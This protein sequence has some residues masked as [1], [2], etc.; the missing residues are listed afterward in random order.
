MRGLFDRFMTAFNRRVERAI[1]RI[2]RMDLGVEN[3]SARI[4]GRFITLSGVAPDR[5]VSARVI[6]L[7]KQ[8]VG[9]DNILNAINVIEPAPDNGS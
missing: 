2:E 8:Y 1:R 5:E 6:E 3:L 4:E 9:F 7:F